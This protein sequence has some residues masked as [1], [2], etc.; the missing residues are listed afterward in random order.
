MACSISNFSCSLCPYMGTQ[1]CIEYSTHKD[2]DYS[3]CFIYAIDRKHGYLNA[4]YKAK[5]RKLV[6]EKLNSIANGSFHPNWSKMYQYC[7]DLGE[8]KYDK[9]KGWHYPDY[10]EFYIPFI[11]IVVTDNEYNWT[12]AMRLVLDLENK[13]LMNYDKGET[14]LRNGIM[15]L[16]DEWD[17]NLNFKE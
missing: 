16:T 4:I 10:K 1:T 11:E 5:D 17:G 7:L 9:K 8:E 15:K 6:I 13:R 3:K 2:K 12:T 14:C